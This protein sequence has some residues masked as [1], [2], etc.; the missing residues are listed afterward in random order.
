M[1]ST[2][3]HFPKYHFCAKDTLNETK[4]DPEVNCYHVGIPYL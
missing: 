3:N 4:Q 1:A 2:L